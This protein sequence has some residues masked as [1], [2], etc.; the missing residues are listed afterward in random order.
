[1]DGTEMNSV[2]ISMIS[3]HY[4]CGIEDA[5]GCQGFFG[6]ECSPRVSVMSI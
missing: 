2:H 5:L 4:Y 1:M 3:G 6:S